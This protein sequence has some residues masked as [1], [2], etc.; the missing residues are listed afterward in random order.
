MKSD[1]K[2]HQ[3]GPGAAHIRHW[4]FGA[5]GPLL[6]PEDGGN[7]AGGSG[8]GTSGTTT[9]TTTTEGTPGTAPAGAGG[10]KL[11]TQAQVNALVAQARREGRES[12]TQQTTQQTTTPPPKATTA[13]AGE[14]QPMTAEAVQQLMQRE[15][16]FTRATATAGLTEKQLARMEEAFNVAKPADVAAWSST[17]LE[18]MGFAKPGTQQQSQNGSTQAGS[19][20]TSA[21]AATTVPGRVEPGTNGGLVDIW[22][23]SGDQIEQLGP[24][25]I[26][27]EHEKILAHANKRSGAPP[28]PRVMQRK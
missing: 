12:A 19:T 26:R 20:T 27:E 4:M 18:D 3:R 25:G 7:G 21:A 23:L 2:N 1:T 5:R 10:E 14:A 28:V 6:A 13:P 16:A 15:R 22:N 8:G 17:Y 11:L 9:T 24:Q